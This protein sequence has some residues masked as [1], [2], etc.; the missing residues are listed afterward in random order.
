MQHSTCTGPECVRRAVYLEYCAG[1]YRQWRLGKDLTV[2]RVYTRFADHETCSVPGC[3]RPYKARGLCNTH[4]K[5]MKRYGETRTIK[6]YDLVGRVCN[7][8]DC[9]NPA[10]AKL[11][12]NKHLSYGYNLSR[13]GISLEDFVRLLDAQGGGCAICGGT[14]ANGKALG[15]DHDHDCC[16][17]DRSCGRCVRGLLC[18]ACNF[19]IGMMRD[20]PTRLRAAAE[21][22]HSFVPEVA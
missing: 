9:E 17:G 4:N 2:L 13:F 15:V 8:A 22:I 14:N 20:D 1:H 19:A 11:R 21:Y 10:M 16:A 6:T 12:C 18:S 7:I 5:H 3:G